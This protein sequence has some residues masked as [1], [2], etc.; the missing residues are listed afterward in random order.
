M[1]AVCVSKAL[2][3]LVFELEE[4]ATSLS[5]TA[6]RQ[7]KGL[8]TTKQDK[9]VMRVDDQFELICTMLF[10]P[11]M[12]YKY[13]RDRIES[14]LVTQLIRNTANRP[15]AVFKIPYKDIRVAVIRDPCHNNGEVLT[16]HSAFGDTK[17]YLGER[18]G[19]PCSVLQFLLH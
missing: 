17:T 1:A 7:R 10:S 18:I 6:S 3:P 14:V 11:H 5:S 4:L 16:I 15:D 13:E 12:I 2:E 9:P 19:I 8:R